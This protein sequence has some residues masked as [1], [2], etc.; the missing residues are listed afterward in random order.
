MSKEPHHLSYWSLTSLFSWSLTPFL[1][2]T[3]QAVIL[4]IHYYDYTLSRFYKSLHAFSKSPLHHFVLHYQPTANPPPHP[5]HIM[6]SLTHPPPPILTHSN[7]QQALLRLTPINLPVRRVRQQI[8]HLPVHL[9]PPPALDPVRLLLQLRR[10]VVVR[11]VVDALPDVEGGLF[12][13]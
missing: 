9:I 13:V 12:R 1:D 6:H 8:P 3:G 10:G 11:F 7:N 5:P 4:V 2:A